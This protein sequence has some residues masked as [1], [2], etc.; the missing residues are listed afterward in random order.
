[1]AA[2]DDIFRIKSISQLHEAFGYEKPKH[3]LISII[4]ISEAEVTKE[5]I[6]LRLAANLY[7][8]ALK[9]GDCGVMYG[10]NHYDFE[11]GVLVFT[12]PNQVITLTGEV[13][14]ESQKNGW[15]LFFHPDL[16]RK[17]ALGENIDDYTFFSYQSHEALHLADSEKNTLAD[18]IK[19]IKEEYHERID[20]HSQRLIIS[21]LELL[22]NY[23]ARF[24]ERQF[25]TR[26]N[27]NSDIV[28]KLEKLLRSYF[29]SQ[30]L[31]ELGPPSIQ[32]CADKMNLSPNYLSDLLKKETGK[33]TKDHIND[34]V[35]E[36]AKNKL[37]NSNDSIN[38]IAYAL[39]FN[40]PHY[41]S[42]LFKNKTGVSPL[43]YREL[44]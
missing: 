13:S 11:E 40:Y 34:F 41:F 23:C 24:Y 39:G 32:Y 27:Y 8:I 1:M 18:C 16:I 33:S 29:H 15:M 20:N 38:E 42:R 43:A 25:N 35:V 21:N 22:L 14:P 17:S 10:R 26:K 2:K 37:V 4:D 6:G 31:P 44:N 5:M 3:P 9:G 12:P 28:T 30:D 7:S 36:Q 19:K